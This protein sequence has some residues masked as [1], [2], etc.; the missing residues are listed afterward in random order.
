MNKYNNNKNVRGLGLQ[1]SQR[2]LISLVL[3]STVAA[4]GVICNVT[5]IHAADY[6]GR[7]LYLLENW[8]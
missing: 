2:F 7:V 5:S 6:L 4:L 1:V 8:L 3:M